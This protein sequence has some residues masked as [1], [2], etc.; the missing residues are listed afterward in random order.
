MSVILREAQ[1]RLQSSWLQAARAGGKNP[2]DCCV[3]LQKDS[4]TVYLEQELES[5]KVVLDIKNTQL[6]QQEKTL[7]EIDKLVRREAESV[8]LLA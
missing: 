4:H 2:S 7:I 8:F 5:L 6:H 1:R 3:S